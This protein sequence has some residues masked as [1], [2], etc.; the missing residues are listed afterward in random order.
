MPIGGGGEG[1]ADEGR[2]CR[3]LEVEVSRVAELEEVP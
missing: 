1:C 2:S 3:V